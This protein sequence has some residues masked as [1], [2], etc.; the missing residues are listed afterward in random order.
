LAACHER[1]HE[2]T[3]LDAHRAK[4][5]GAYSVSVLECSYLSDCWEPL[6]SLLIT[7]VPC[8]AEQTL[9]MHYLCKKILRQPAD[10]VFQL[11]LVCAGG[12]SV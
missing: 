4:S 12:R 6:C 9:R 11:Q 7:S 8:S 5:S 1:S 10:A 2:T 3:W